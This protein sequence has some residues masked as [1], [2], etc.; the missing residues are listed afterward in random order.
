M[1]EEGQDISSEEQLIPTLI[2]FCQEA[3][4]CQEDRLVSSFGYCRSLGQATAAMMNTTLRG[5][6]PIIAEAF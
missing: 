5:T 3:M 1:G 4:P 2:F 6:Y